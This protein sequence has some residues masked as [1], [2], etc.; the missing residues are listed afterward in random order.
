MPD[1]SVHCVVSSPPYWGLRDYGSPDQIGLEPA[2]ADYIAGMVE[3]FREIR[4]VLRP[5]GT[6]W[7]NMG[8]TYISGG[9]ERP[10]AA[11]G[12][13]QPHDEERGE[14]G[15]PARIR[16]SG[17]K[18]KD[19]AGVPW[20]LAL[21]LQDDGWWLRRDIIWAKPNP[22]PESASDRPTTSHEYVFLLTK[23]GNTTYWSHRDGPGSRTRPAP[24]YR[25]VDLDSEVVGDGTFQM[26][27]G[28]QVGATGRAHSTP[29]HNQGDKGHPVY[30]AADPQYAETALEPENW[31]TER[32]AKRPSRK[33]WRRINLWRGHDYFYDQDAVREVGVTPAGT[34]GAKGS[35]ERAAIP[36]VNARPAEYKLYD[37]E[38][39]LRS[40]WTITTVAY[41]GAHFATFPPTL[42]E[43]CIKAG[44]SERGCCPKCGAPIIR[45][46]LRTFMPQ[47][48]VSLERGINGAP[49]Q[50][51]LDASSGWDGAPRGSVWSE[52]LGWVPSCGCAAGKPVPCVVLDPFGGAGT[53]G[54]VADRMQ[55]DALLVEAVGDY[56]EMARKRIVD[57]S[58]L[59]AVVAMRTGA[60][61]RPTPALEAGCKSGSRGGE[62][63]PTTTK[64]IDTLSD[65]GVSNNDVGAETIVEQAERDLA[66]VAPIF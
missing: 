66:D 54:L 49:G 15:R 37:G 65:P 64:Q 20:R 45:R 59:L 6:V 38:R 1:A 32:S 63:S 23:R 52:T 10:G 41:P 13:H 36:G 26:P 35:E 61:V 11:A 16:R 29:G 3:L 30:V 62:V 4:R 48:D 27:S 18:P 7:L 17:L 9:G 24:D 44:T 56:C 39:N 28:W 51:P 14:V 21:A 43:T 19:L 57:A 5:D 31:Q 46:A 34:L 2:L 58:P 33:R 50:K 8:D 53:V 55:R 40:V 42:A 12:K 47:P 22:M 60:A 25:W